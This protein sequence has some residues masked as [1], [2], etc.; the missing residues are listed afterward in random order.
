MKFIKWIKQSLSAL[1]AAL[2]TVLTCSVCPFCL[3]LY[4]GGASALGLEASH[5]TSLILFWVFVVGV[6]FTLGLMIRQTIQKHRKW[7]PFC[8]ALMGVLVLFFSKIYC[9]KQWVSIVGFLIFA[10]GLIWHKRL[11]HCYGKTC[12]THNH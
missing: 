11:S 6:L 8:I 3:P 1:P 7:L 10:T 12:V 9:L 2:L 4:I 5:T